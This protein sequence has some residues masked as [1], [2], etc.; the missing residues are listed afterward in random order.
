MDASQKQ[1][2]LPGK[3]PMLQVLE[4]AQI[5][6]EECDEVVSLAS[7]GV[8]TT[9]FGCGPHETFLI[10]CLVMIELDVLRWGVAQSTTLPHFPQLPVNSQ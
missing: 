8:M 7:I 3:V 2:V 5:T 1:R 9:I 10:D 6:L 4:D